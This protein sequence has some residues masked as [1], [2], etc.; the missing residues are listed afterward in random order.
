VWLR[1]GAAGLDADQIAAVVHGGG[2]PGAQ[3]EKVDP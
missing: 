1:R 3:S 2:G